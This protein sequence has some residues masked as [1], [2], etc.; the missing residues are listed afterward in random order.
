MLVAVQSRGEILAN[1]LVA[2]SASVATRNRPLYR[3]IWDM[4]WLRRKK[5]EILAPLVQAEIRGHQASPSW[6]EQAIRKSGEITRSPGFRPEMRRFLRRD[7]AR[8]SLDNPQCIEFL[9]QET[10]DLSRETM[11]AVGEGTS[12]GS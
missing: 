1:K 3:D 6:F 4:C 7:V 10:E 2:F 12:S 5:T 8:E 11:R 9:T